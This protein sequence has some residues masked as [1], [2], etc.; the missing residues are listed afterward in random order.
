MT[1]VEKMQ[2]NYQKKI[3]PMIKVTG[4]S[5]LA[6]G[7]EGRNLASGLDRREYCKQFDCKKSQKVIIRFNLKD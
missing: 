1:D 6:D 2:F 3:I 7:V 5:Y 4:R